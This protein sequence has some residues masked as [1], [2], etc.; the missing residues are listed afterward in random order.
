MNAQAERMKN[1][2]QS[3]AATTFDPLKDSL[4]SLFDQ[5]AG[6]FE[7]LQKYMKASPNLQSAAS[8][9]LG[10]AAV[11]G[12]GYA[13]WKLLKGGS[14]MIRGLRAIGGTAVGVAEGKVLQKAA[15]VTPVFVVNMPNAGS[16][17]GGLL[18]DAATGAGAVAAGSKIKTA[19]TGLRLLTAAPT[20]TA[21][22]SLG[23]GAMAVSAGLVSAAGLVG[24]GA[25]TLANKAL[26][27]GTPLADKIGR[28]IATIM[29]SFGN[30]EA[31]QALNI[32][33]H[34]DG[35][36]VA[37]VVNAQNTTQARRH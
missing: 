16:S 37:T 2:F 29:A 11:L 21:L 13:L 10:G 14:G 25:G 22:A 36:Q 32:N 1:N 26:I 6:G 24:Y 18:G 27:E 19:M 35:K 28:T 23:T 30:K 31:Q 7:S 20:M 33:L 17:T 9:G 15:G 34:I 5:L 12:G 4:K 3:L 8:T